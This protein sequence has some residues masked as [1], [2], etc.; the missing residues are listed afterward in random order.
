MILNIDRFN[1][2]GKFVTTEAAD[3]IESIKYTNQPNR[4][5]QN[6]MRQTELIKI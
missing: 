1:R 6:I 3:N 4:A 2:L 5:K